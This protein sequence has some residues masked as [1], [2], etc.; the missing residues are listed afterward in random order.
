[1][2]TD[3]TTT[4]P[5]LTASQRRRVREL[6]DDEGYTRAEARAWVA[7]FEPHDTIPCPPPAEVMQ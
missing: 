3:S 7:A 2:N 4:K 6:V 1:M 5:K